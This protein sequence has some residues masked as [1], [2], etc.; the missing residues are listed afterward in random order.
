MHSWM[1]LW[2]E[3]EEGVEDV[4]AQV[5]GD[6]GGGRHAAESDEIGAD[7]EGYGLGL[8][9][10]RDSHSSIQ[11]VTEVR[12]VEKELAHLLRI[13]VFQP[14]TAD[15]SNV[16]I[17]RE[18]VLELAGK[19][20]FVEDD[21]DGAGNSGFASGPLTTRGSISLSKQGLRAE[22]KKNHETC[23]GSTHMCRLCSISI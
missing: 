2:I 15:D 4:F 12:V 13:M 22:V 3:V 6:V 7:D 5:S 21:L 8:K 10:G 19:V 20:D 17:A 23:A 11:I 14:A 16:D 9:K 18:H 1:L